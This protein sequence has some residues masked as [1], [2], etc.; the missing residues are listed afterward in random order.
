MDEADALDTIERDEEDHWFAIS[1]EQMQ[2]PEHMRK[3]RGE[4]EEATLKKEQLR[5]EHDKANPV[6]ALVARNR[7]LFEKI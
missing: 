4:S 3:V 7:K 6:N 5:T 1:L 2:Y